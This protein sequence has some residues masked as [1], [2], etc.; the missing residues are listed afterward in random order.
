MRLLG[1]KLCVCSASGDTVNKFTNVD[2]PICTPISVMSFSFS[3]PLPT[4]GI[5]SF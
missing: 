1:P 5:F 3:T 2:V 4:F